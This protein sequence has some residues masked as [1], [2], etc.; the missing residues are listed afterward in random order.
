[1]SAM[2]KWELINLHKC[3][4]PLPYRSGSLLRVF[5]YRVLPPASPSVLSSSN[6]NSGLEFYLLLAPGCLI[7]RPTFWLNEWNICSCLLVPATVMDN[8][9]SKPSHTC[10]DVFLSLCV[11]PGGVPKDQQGPGGTPVPDPD[12]KILFTDFFF[13]F[14]CFCFRL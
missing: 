4:S 14:C 6:I 8:Q 1:M 7:F 9:L 2:L 3:V 12:N 10:C 5:L 13:S 11:K